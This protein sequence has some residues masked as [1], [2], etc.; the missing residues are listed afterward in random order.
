MPMH[1]YVFT[2][3][4]A[5]WP[6]GSV[7]ARL[8]QIDISGGKKISASAWLDRHKSVEQ[9][10]WAPGLP[11][12]I[13]DWL[14]HDGGWLDRKGVSCFNLYMPP[15]LIGGD[16]AQAGP[17]LDHLRLIYPENADHIISW[18]AHR[19]QRP[20]EKINHALVLGGGHGIGKDSLLEPVSKR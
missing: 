9:M 8:G 2:P 11:M 16:P 14:V 18:L 12:I 7:N 13:R 5:M 4:R 10:T 17:W 19:V 3:T 1:N 6:A 15:T 20:H